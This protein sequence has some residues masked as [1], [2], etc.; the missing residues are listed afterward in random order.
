MLHVVLQVDQ[1]QCTITQDYHY[2]QW[3]D[4]TKSLKNRRDEVAEEYG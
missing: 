4:T 2:Q 3:R 1:I